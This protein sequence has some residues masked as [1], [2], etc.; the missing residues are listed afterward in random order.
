MIIPVMIL[1]VKILIQAL[2]ILSFIEMLMVQNVL[3]SLQ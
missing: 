3:E 1:L 2:A